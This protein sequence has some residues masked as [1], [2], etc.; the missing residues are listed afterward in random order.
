MNKINFSN[1]IEYAMVDLHLHFDGAISIKIVEELIKLQPN[2]KLTDW[3]M[4]TD[5][6][7][8]QL[9]SVT[10][11]CESLN[12]YLKKFDYPE[13][14]LQS[15]QT[16][17][18]AIKILVQDLEEQGYIYADIRF[19]PQLFSTDLRSTLS[20]KM[21]KQEEEEIFQ[22]E[23]QIVKAALEGIEEAKL[24]NMEA[25][26]ILCCMRN[27][28]WNRFD[29]LE[30]QNANERTIKIASL[31]EHYCNKNK[32]LVTPRITKL[33]IAG[34]EAGNKN[35]DYIN[36]YKVY[37]KYNFKNIGLTIHSGEAGTIQERLE[38]LSM[39]INKTNANIGHGVIIGEIYKNDIPK[40]YKEQILDLMYKLVNS[41]RVLEICI[42]SNYQTKAINGVHPIV[43]MIMGD[44][45]QGIPELTS[46]I[47][48]NTDNPVVSNTTLKKELELFVKIC[49]DMGLNEKEI[50]LKLLQ[51][52]KNSIVQ[53]G[54]S[55]K[56]KKKYLYEISKKLEQVQE[57]YMNN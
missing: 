42:T 19:A 45:A 29:K 23:F 53:S 55:E 46:N 11:E 20:K 57:E 54:L 47:T 25:N 24:E 16:V 39:V 41:D 1:I 31:L 28:N 12:E 38:N 5:K 34:G 51:I 15:P 3:D 35:E 22:H 32:S 26:I 36:L 48:I 17:K 9:L 44:R 14:L 30:N 43:K 50:A 37:K 27:K 6:G 7:K 18:L 13:K 40:T 2:K 33:D 49:I 8:K 21:T 52:K 56:K 4:L 10:E